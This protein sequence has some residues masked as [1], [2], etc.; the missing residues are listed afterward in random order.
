MN[1]NE[2]YQL[3]KKGDGKAL[4]IMVTRDQKT[5][6]AMVKLQRII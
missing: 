5:F 2:V 4:D 1:I 6:F 3:M